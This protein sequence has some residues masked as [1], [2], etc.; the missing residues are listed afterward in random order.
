M[1]WQYKRMGE[2][3]FVEQ[4]NDIAKEWIAE[5]PG[6]FVQLTF[7]RIVYFWAGLP[8]KGLGL[9][10]QGRNLM[11]ALSSLLAIGGLLLAAKRCVHGVFLFA[12]L[13]LFY[14]LIYYIT[15]PSARYRHAIEPELIV[16]VVYLIAEVCCGM[17][18][19]RRPAAA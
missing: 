12:S 1:Y 9:G 18:S 4:E 16:L 17:L 6:R 3:A 7:L 2:V 8:R 10:Q 11:M 13:I 5:N 15:F 19:R 14:P